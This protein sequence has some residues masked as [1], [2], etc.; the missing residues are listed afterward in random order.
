MLLSGLYTCAMALAQ[1]T[2]AHAHTHE[3]SGVKN[4][5]DQNS[6]PNT[7]VRQLTTFQLLGITNLKPLQAPVHICTYLHSD[8]HAYI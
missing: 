1:H 7:H 8:P 2:Q 4:A 6:I 5:E 3:R